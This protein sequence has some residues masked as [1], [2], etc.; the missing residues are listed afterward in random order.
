MSERGIRNNTG[1]ADR[2]NSGKERWS[3]VDF[4][5]LKPM[6]EVLA[7]GAKKYSDDNW[8]KG[9]KT[10]EVCESLIRHLTAYLAGQDNDSE[11]ELPEVG[12]IL[13]NAMFLS[14]M[15]LFRPDMDN[16]GKKEERVLDDPNFR[17]IA[18]DFANR[19]KNMKD[20]PPKMTVTNLPCSASYEKWI[21]EAEELD[22]VLSSEEVQ[23][24][25][26]GSQYPKEPVKEGATNQDILNVMTAIAQAN[27]MPKSLKLIMMENLKNRM[28]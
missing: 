28:K 10:K 2:H 4:E 25:K 23:N 13:C 6:V 11:S 24:A 7:F 9:L 27:Y 18:E 5:A 19:L 15:H 12:H 16:R 3:L 1:V 21:K 8:K 26:V 20:E 22:K 17:Q 14:H